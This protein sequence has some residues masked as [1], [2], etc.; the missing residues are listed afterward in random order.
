MSEKLSSNEKRA[1]LSLSSILSL[2]MMGLFMVLPVFSLYASQLPQATP[3]LIGLSMGIYGFFQA[4]FQIPF[5]ALSDRVGRKPII[6][7]GLFIFAS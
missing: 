5:G 7:L 4:L 1:I 6:L 2:R 3:T